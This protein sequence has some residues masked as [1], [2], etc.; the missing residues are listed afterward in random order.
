M[1]FL[2]ALSFLYCVHCVDSVQER[3]NPLAPTLASE[4][5]GLMAFLEALSFLYCVHC[6]DS[7]QDG[8]MDGTRRPDVTVAPDGGNPIMMDNRFD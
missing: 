8:D 5:C 3:A 2:E 1:A 4:A 7:V 6:V